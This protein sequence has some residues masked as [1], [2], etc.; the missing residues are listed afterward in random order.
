[1][2]SPDRNGGKSQRKLI[3]PKAQ[4]VLTRLDQEDTLDYN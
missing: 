3:V 1:M 2:D 4:K